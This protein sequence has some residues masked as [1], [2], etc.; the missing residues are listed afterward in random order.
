LKFA[1]LYQ[2]VEKFDEIVES[3]VVGQQ[4]HDDIRIILF[5]HLRHANQLTQQLKEK[6]K[7]QI[8]QQLSPRHVPNKIIQIDDIPKTMNGKIVELAIRDMIHG[9]PIKNKEAIA[10]P[11][12][13]E[14][15]ANIKELQIE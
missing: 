7:A 13:L 6:I 4:W 15:F 14:Q 2:Q 9:I 10:N 11:Q 1:E 3:V 8:R 12:A 5:V